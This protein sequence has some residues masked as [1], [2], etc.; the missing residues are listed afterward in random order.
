MLRVQQYVH[1]S[2]P[3]N[4]ARLDLHFDLAT[5]LLAICTFIQLSAHSAHNLQAQRV[6]YDVAAIYAVR[7]A[8]VAHTDTLTTM[9]RTCH[10]GIVS[11]RR[12]N[13]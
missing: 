11:L 2:A 13:L 12:E 8:L 9:Y 4:L 7:L 3:S 10:T 6:L 1:V 5:P